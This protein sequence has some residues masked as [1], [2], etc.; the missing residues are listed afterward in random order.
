MMNM[1]VGST[2]ID[3]SKLKLCDTVHK[4]NEYSISLVPEY[5]RH[6]KEICDNQKYL[7][8]MHLRR[9]DDIPF[10]KRVELS[11]KLLTD[12][13]ITGDIT[14]ISSIE[15]IILSSD[16]DYLMHLLF[17]KDGDTGDKR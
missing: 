2:T 7:V 6:R 10:Y 9:C 17:Q 3:K 4:L 8:A 1:I 15:D 5:I 11:N 16:V 13:E 12:V 14:S